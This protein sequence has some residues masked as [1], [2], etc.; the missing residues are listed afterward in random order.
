MTILNKD[1]AVRWLKKKPYL[2][3]QLLGFDKLTE[4]HNEWI[5]QMVFGK[6][7]VTLQAHRGSYKT[8]CVSIALA[9]IMVIY[10]TYKILFMRKTDSDVKE[11]VTQVKKIIE[12]PEV[13]AFVLALYNTPLVLTVANATELSTN[14]CIGVSGASQLNAIG[15]TSSLTGKHYDRIFTDDIVNIKDRISKAERDR[16]KIIYQELQN[17][18][19]RDG[20]IFNTGTPWHEDDC[21]KIMPNIEKYDYKRTGLIDDDDIEK[22]KEKMTASLFSCNYELRHIA[23]DDVIF[24]NPIIGAD[25]Y[26]VEQGVCHI[27]AAYGGEDYT[28]FTICK[29]RNTEYYVL[30]KIWHKAVDECLDEIIAIRKM[31]NAGKISC[32][33][34]ADKGY[35]AKD[36]RNRG[37]RTSLYHEKMNKFIKI[38]SYLKAEWRHVHFAKC[39]DEEY[40]NQICDY[41][42]NAE[43]DDAPDS[44]ASLIRILWKK[45]GKAPE[46][47]E[48]SWML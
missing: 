13:Q 20:R 46:N 3:G 32:E 19:N 27:D 43:H 14:L 11:I 25:P 26:L 10:P 2:L 17:I 7:D 24:T 5:K 1:N 9:M 38:T 28:A 29:K 30:G 23:S 21:F 47:I 41:T 35:L 42:E 8:T 12:S 37:E 6:E 33:K 39:T 15:I 34:N 48:K 45:K 16:T 40:I 4:L 22:I 31:F 36:L 44:L 18:K